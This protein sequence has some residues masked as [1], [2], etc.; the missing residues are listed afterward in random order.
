MRNTNRKTGFY[1]FIVFL[2]AIAGSLIG[3]TIGNNVKSLEF[4]RK[5]YTIGTMQPISLNLKVINLSLGFN[6]NLNLMSIIGAVL[7]IIIAR[8]F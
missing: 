5:V 6:F 7:A 4:F 3:D 2:G 8:K 1:V